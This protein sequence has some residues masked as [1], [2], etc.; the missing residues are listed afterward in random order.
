MQHNRGYNTFFYTL[1]LQ[2]NGQIDR[3]EPVVVRRQLFDED[4]AIKTLTGIQN[5]FAYGV[6]GRFVNSKR[7]EFALAGYA[8]QVFLLD[9]SER[10]PR[11]KTIVNG[12]EIFLNRMFLYQ[13]EGSTGLNTKLDYILFFGLNTSVRPVVEKLIP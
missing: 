9:L 8:N 11:V 12:R 3:K 1:N 4:G 13:T 5:R 10:K 7:Y 6:K 2:A